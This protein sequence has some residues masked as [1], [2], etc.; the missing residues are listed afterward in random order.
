[1]MLEVVLYGYLAGVRSSRKLE[2]GC[3]EQVAF[4]FLAAN[5]TPDHRAF[6]RFRR[7]HLAAMDGLFVQVLGLCA[8]AGMV[9]L[10]NVGLDGTKV[11]ANAS[12]HKAMSYARMKA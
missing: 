4:R 8:I 10:G 9:K 3:V 11:R 5:Q 2:A 6:S 12:R 7:R 1:M